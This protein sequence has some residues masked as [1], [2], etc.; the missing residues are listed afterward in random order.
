MSG[1]RAKIKQQ[2]GFV[3]ER[4]EGT[5]ETQGFLID[6]GNRICQTLESQVTPEWTPAAKVLPFGTE[7]LPFTNGQT[8]RFSSQSA[9]VA[10]TNHQLNANNIRLGSEEFYGMFFDPF[11][12]AFAAYLKSVTVQT[13][14]GQ[15]FFATALPKQEQPTA[16]YHWLHDFGWRGM[17]VRIRSEAHPQ[18]GCLLFRFWFIVAQLE[19]N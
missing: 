2:A 8:W 18:A 3:I 6:V 7:L 14:Q 15:C 13:S 4:P 1:H 17:P 19:G 12:L 16:P 10:I 11:T 9:A 5:S